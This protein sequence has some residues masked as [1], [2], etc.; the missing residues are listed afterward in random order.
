[1][2]C[3]SLNVRHRLAIE[4]PPI[5]LGIQSG[6]TLPLYNLNFTPGHVK[7]AKRFDFIWIFL[8]KSHTGSIA[9]RRNINL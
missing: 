5:W 3:I 2:Q 7:I 6:K 8:N 9:K 4:N 1:M